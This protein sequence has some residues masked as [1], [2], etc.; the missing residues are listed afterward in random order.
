MEP[1]QIAVTVAGAGL[2]GFVLWFFFGPRVATAARSTAGGVQEAQIEVRA[3]YTPDRVEV[4]AG[5]PVRLTFV[6][7]EANPCTEQVILPEFGIV[8]DLPVGRPVAV[9]FTPTRP[10]EFEFHCGM[11]MV[12]G[13]L[14]V[15]PAPGRT[16]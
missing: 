5:R 11:N 8:R 2:V 14:V 6:R 7:R 3:S 15:R 13:R 9:E 1:S 4:V 16:P 10:G 12:R